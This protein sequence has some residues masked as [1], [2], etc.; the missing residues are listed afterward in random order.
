MINEIKIYVGVPDIYLN[1]LKH[2]SLSLKNILNK[3]K[4]GVIA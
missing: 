3:I 2:I 1:N 4:S